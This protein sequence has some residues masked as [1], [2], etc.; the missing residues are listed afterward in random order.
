MITYDLCALLPAAT[1]WPMFADGFEGAPAIWKDGPQADELPKLTSM[2][3]R[4]H[5]EGYSANLCQIGQQSFACALQA[6]VRTRKSSRGMQGS[7]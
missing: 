2:H 6:P 3:S 4:L 7:G 5:M 1:S